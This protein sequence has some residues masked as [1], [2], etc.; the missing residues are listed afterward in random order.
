MILQTYIRRTPVY[1]QAKPEEDIGQKTHLTMRDAKYLLA[2]DD[3][4]D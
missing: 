3:E 2:V 1:F 4:L